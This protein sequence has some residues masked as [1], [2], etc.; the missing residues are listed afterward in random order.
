MTTVSAFEGNR[1][2]QSGKPE[3]KITEQAGDDQPFEEDKKGK[4]LE[5]PEIR[6]ANI[7][8]ESNRII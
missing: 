2:K 4:R 1:N 6:P 5:R 7:R 8:K 3:Q